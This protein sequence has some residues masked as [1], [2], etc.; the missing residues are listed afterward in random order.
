MIKKEV[1]LSLVLVGALVVVLLFTFSNDSSRVTGYFLFGGIS[2]NSVNQ[3][4][5]SE[6]FTIPDSGN[7]QSSSLPSLLDNPRNKMIAYA[8]FIIVVVAGVIIITWGSWNKKSR[9]VKA[10]K[11]LKRK[12]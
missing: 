5:A 1:G 8:I 10:L 7:L 12:K 9:D 6:N 4:A 3:N 2:G 11:T